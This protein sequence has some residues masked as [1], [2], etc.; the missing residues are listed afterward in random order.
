MSVAFSMFLSNFPYGKEQ[1]Y[2]FVNLLP[3]IT[4]ATSF[5]YILQFIL[6]IYNVLNSVFGYLYQQARPVSGKPSDP[7]R[8]VDVPSTGLTTSVFPECKTLGDLFAR[9]C[10]LYSSHPCLGTRDVISEDEEVQPNGKVFKKVCCC[11]VSA[12][13]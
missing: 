12:C 11:P 4:L 5:V 13:V 6:K 3:V 8:S 7:W 10:R 1:Y 9:A 2:I